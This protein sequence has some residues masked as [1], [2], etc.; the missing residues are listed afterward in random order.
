M[1]VLWLV[2]L[3]FLFYDHSHGRQ[4]GFHSIQNTQGTSMVTSYCLS[5]SKSISRNQEYNLRQDQIL[6]LLAKDG[7]NPC[8]NNVSSPCFQD[9]TYTWHSENKYICRNWR[10]LV[11][12]ETQLLKSLNN[13][14]VFNM[15]GNWGKATSPQSWMEFD[16]F[17]CQPCSE[18]KSKSQEI[19]LLH[20]K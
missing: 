10:E 7:S 18:K 1:F 4:V 9:L 15:T 12:Q 5:P 6:S 16:N 3:E 17:S 20:K 19:A 8:G 11:F 14:Y 2:H 13:G